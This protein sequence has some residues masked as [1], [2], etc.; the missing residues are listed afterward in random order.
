MN[1]AGIAQIADQAERQLWQFIDK[2]LRA[3][4]DPLVV[5]IKDMECAGVHVFQRQPQGVIP[6]AVK[7]L[8]FI[9]NDR[10]IGKV[11]AGLHRMFQR[12]GQ[13]LAVKHWAL[14]IGHRNFG[15]MG[16]LAA[17]FMKP[18]DCQVL[19]LAD[20]T[21]QMRRKR[22]VKAREQSARACFRATHGLFQR[23]QGFASASRPGDG[24]LWISGQRF[25]HKGLF[26]GQKFDLFHVMGQRAG[27]M[28]PQFKFGRNDFVKRPH[29]LGAKWIAG[30]GTAH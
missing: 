21:L 24:H 23:K 18:G 27:Q 28:R 15:L 26:G 19:Y 20:K 17:K 6:V 29:A 16:Q 5:I 1:R 14:E 7:V 25:Q 22:V 9:D 4:I 3:T 13:G 8:A 10:V 30:L 12:I 11:R 2:A